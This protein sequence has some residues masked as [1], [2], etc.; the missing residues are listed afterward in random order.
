MS[1]HHF[2]CLLYLSGIVDNCKGQNK[3][4]PTNYDVHLAESLFKQAPERENK[5]L[6]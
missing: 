4:S 6:L 5:M 1:L 2:T 3:K